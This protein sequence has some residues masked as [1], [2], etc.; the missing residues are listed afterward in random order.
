MYYDINLISKIVCKKPTIFHPL[1]SKLCR[2]GVVYTTDLLGIYFIFCNVLKCLIVAIFFIFYCI[3][4]VCYE[5]LDEKNINPLTKGIYTPF[6]YEIYISFFHGL[7]KFVSGSIFLSFHNIFLL[8]KVYIIYIY[9]YIYY[10][11]I[12]LLINNIF[13]KKYKNFKTKKVKFSKSKKHPNFQK[14]SFF[15]FLKSHL[16][17]Y[18][19][20]LK[21]N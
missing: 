14:K 19:I 8:V 15:N 4:I 1:N 2:R 18:F 12:I 16:I 6:K 3:F 21:Y 10:L 9:I 20:K 13:I 7:I 5:A 17:I 11:K